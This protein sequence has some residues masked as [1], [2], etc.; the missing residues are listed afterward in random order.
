MKENKIIIRVGSVHNG[1]CIIEHKFRLT[2]DDNWIPREDQ[3]LAELE[4][5]LKSDHDCIVVRSDHKL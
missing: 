3:F 1:E 5:W 4:K 2:W